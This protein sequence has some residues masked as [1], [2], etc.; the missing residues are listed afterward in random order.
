MTD[1]GERLCGTSESGRMM[2]GGE[3][4]QKGNAEIAVCC[5]AEKG[6]TDDIGVREVQGDPAAE[7]DA[8]RM[9][10]GAGPGEACEETAQKV[11]AAGSQ[12]NAQSQQGQ[13]RAGAGGPILCLAEM[14][15]L[16]N[17]GLCDGQ[18][19]I[20][21]GRVSLCE[22]KGETAAICGRQGGGGAL[23]ELRGGVSVLVWA[24]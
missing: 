5:T 1:S 22:E 14:D 9:L 3:K 17:G 6:G 18:N 12:P 20:G 21:T 19:G 2:D 7:R 16:L 13:Q 10:P 24:S 15:A 8:E 23:E 11:V 4:L